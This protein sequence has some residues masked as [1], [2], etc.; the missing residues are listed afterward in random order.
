MKRLSK[1]QLF[2]IIGLILLV[3]CEKDETFS[4]NRVCDKEYFY[5]TSNLDSKVFF[6]QSLNEVWIVFEQDVVSKELAE[7]ILGKYSFIEMSTIMANNFNQVSARINEDVSD[8]SIVNNYLKVLNEDE[9]IFSATPVFYFN[10][11]DPDSYMIL[12]SEVLTKNDAQYISEPDF[13]D[14]AETLNLELVEAKHSTQYFKVKEVI[15][16]FEA[17]EISNLIFKNGK[18]EYANPNFIAKIELN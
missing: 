4:S 7:S 18:V 15:T 10:E 12:L 3:S 1:Y 11:N 13:I 6:K 14:Y 2:I 16:G 5:Y 8:C 17:L 9:E